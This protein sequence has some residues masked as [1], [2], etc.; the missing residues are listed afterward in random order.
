MTSWSS[1]PMATVGVLLGLLTLASC[2]RRGSIEEVVPLVPPIARQLPAESPSWALVDVAGAPSRPMH[3]VAFRELVDGREG[4]EIILATPEPNDCDTFRS[5]LLGK[6]A[7]EAGAESLEA[8][9]P[10][11]W[12]VS[13]VFPTWVRL[14]QEHHPATSLGV[15]HSD[16]RRFS[17]QAPELHVTKATSARVV[18]LGHQSGKWEPSGVSADLLY[19][20]DV[21]RCDALTDRVPDWA[22]DPGEGPHGQ[23]QV[24]KTWGSDRKLRET[25]FLSETG[26]ADE[27]GALLLLRCG[28][29]L[30]RTD[31]V[32][33]RT[34][35]FTN[36]D[37]LDVTFVVDDKRG[38]DLPAGVTKDGQQ[39]AVSGP[40]AALLRELPNSDSLV[41]RVQDSELVFST[42]GYAA[43]R[44][45][46]AKLRCLWGT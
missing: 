20:F 28:P 4:R 43:A 19:E 21:A 15:R 45:S 12:L 27:S 26:A 18:G 13:I 42:A 16:G 44:A 14:P 23:W 8:S 22:G 9:A 34:S 46:S 5:M 3:G 32:L 33:R 24:H 6:A 2:A 38:Y 37:Q 30:R 17:I 36:L 39:L 10:A 11:G 25:L 31:I 7:G 35:P 40:P 29:D 1:I 41:V